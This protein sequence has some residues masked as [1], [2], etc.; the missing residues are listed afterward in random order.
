MFVVEK[1]CIRF[2]KYKFLG[3]EDRPLVIEAYNK[4]EARIKLN[5]LLAKNPIL[6]N[7][8]IISES[9]TLPI[10]GE[11]TKKINSVEHVWVGYA[12]SQTGWMP[13]ENFLKM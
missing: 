11:T 7:T 6:K 5:N 12:I 13:L 2:Y 8:P 1:H 4:K 3:Y 9:L 10:Y